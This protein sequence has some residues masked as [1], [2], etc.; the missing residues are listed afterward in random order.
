[1]TAPS[2]PTDDL[3]RV[4]RH[5]ERGT[6]DPATVRA[7]LDAGLVCHL[8][9][10]HDGRPVVVPMLYGRDGDTLVLHGSAASRALRAGGAGLPVCATVTIVDGLVL[11]RSAFHSSA[12]YRSVVVHGEAVAIEDRD[13][14]LAALAVL[15]DHVAPGRWDE[16][17]PPTD[18]E[19]AATG[20]LRLSLAHAVAKIRD[21][22]VA[23]DETDL[24]LAVWAGVV[25]LATVVGTPQ[26]AEGLAPDLDLPAAV[27]SASAPAVGAPAALVATDAAVAGDI[28]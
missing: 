25:P 3:L 6:R 27:T 22:G 1:M 23:D 7:I 14:K 18:R 10:L 5:P 15:T 28:R 26:P 21:G 20:V 8:G 19:L 12:N 24:D 11:A 17:R 9:Y 16:A 13:A 2:A 4:R